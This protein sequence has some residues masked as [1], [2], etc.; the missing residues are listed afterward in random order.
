MSVVVAGI[1]RSSVTLCRLGMYENCTDSAPIYYRLIS[2]L[3]SGPSLA[4]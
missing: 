3:S 2:L 4:V 1:V